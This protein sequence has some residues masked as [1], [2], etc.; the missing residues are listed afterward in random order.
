MADCS[1]CGKRAQ[2]G[3]SVTHFMCKHTSHTECN[4]DNFDPRECPACLAAKAIGAKVGDVVTFGGSTVEPRLLDGRDYVEEPGDPIAPSLIVRG[5]STIASRITKSNVPVDPNFKSTRDVLNHRIPIKT[6]WAKHNYGLDH[7]LRDG[8]LIDDFIRNRYKLSDLE[9]FHDISQEGPR[10]ALRAFANG[11][12]LNAS[13]LKDHPDLLPFDHFKRLTNIET[14]QMGELLG[15]HFPEDGSLQCDGDTNW[16]AVDCLNLGLCFDDLKELGLQWREQYQDLM[17]GVPT[18]KIAQVEKDLGTTPEKLRQLVS[19]RQMELEELK[20]AQQEAERLEQVRQL[21][22]EQSLVGEPDE[23][24]YEMYQYYEPQDQDAMGNALYDS[25]DSYEQ[26]EE[27]EE[28]PYFDPVTESVGRYEEPYIEE[29]YQEP[30]P[31]PIARPKIRDVRR[32]EA[33]SVRSAAYKEAKMRER[34]RLKRLGL[35]L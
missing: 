22:Y 31:Q 5:L 13:H 14:H 8:I 25:H 18:S 24:S 2:P 4:R 23:K 10:R 11:L 27:D 21:E 26:Y 30:E 9:Q 12:A 7:M 1:V 32:Q 35:K 19:L 33:P 3:F 6:I 16:T 28:P 17:K 34:E 20:R 29:A 15:L